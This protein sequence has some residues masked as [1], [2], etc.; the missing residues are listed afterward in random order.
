MEEFS[1]PYYQ[2]QNTTLAS[3]TN[4][5]N[6]STPETNNTCH[7]D[8]ILVLSTTIVIMI[9]LSN[10]WVVALFLNNRNL[11]RPAANHLLFG[12]SLV[13]ILNGV[14]LFLI[15]VPTLACNRVMMMSYA[16]AVETINNLCLLVAVGKLLLLSSER[17]VSLLYAVRYEDIVR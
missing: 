16:H 13:D 7:F 4:S 10:C 9:W 17:V 15:V 12:L 3:G 6:N 8:I 11:R 2:M 1:G 14:G 5:M